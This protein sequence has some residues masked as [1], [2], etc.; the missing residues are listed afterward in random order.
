MTA[1]QN[2]MCDTQQHAQPTILEEKLGIVLV[3]CET[4]YLHARAIDVAGGGHGAARAPV[5][6]A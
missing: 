2:A 5:V 6:A 4:P 1:S 3:S